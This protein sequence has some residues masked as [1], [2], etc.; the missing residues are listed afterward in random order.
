VITQTRA[1]RPSSR[2]RTRSRA[3]AR[4]SC[5]RTS[6]SPSSTEVEHVTND[7]AVA[8]ARRL[9]REEGILCG[10]SCGAAMVAALRLAH[11]PAYG[12]DHRGGAARRRRAV[13]RITTMDSAPR[14][15]MT[16]TAEVKIRDRELDEGRGADATE[17]DRQPTREQHAQAG[18]R[19]RAGDE[20]GVARLDGQRLARQ[21]VT[22]GADDRHHQG[23]GED[24]RRAADLRRRGDR[25]GGAE[26]RADRQDRD[27]EQGRRARSAP[28]RASPSRGRMRPWRHRSTTASGH[29]RLRPSRTW[30]PR[31]A[32]S[33]ARRLVSLD[34]DLTQ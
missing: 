19:Q 18:G 7:E 15:R 8:M 10:I 2:R 3:S 31:G 33:P 5:R 34:A 28:P 13:L 14:S 11:D 17:S 12:Q 6:T 22:A 9:A 26:Q 32:R 20:Q 25:A 21:Q 24:H 16:A 27:R 30:G 4:A 1:A 23:R 29:R